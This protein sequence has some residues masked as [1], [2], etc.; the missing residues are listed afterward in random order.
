MVGAST[1]S[2]CIALLP[3]KRSRVAN[4]DKI[5][6]G[7]KSQRC[8][9]TGYSFAGRNRKSAHA[10]KEQFTRARY[11]VVGCA[12]NTDAAIRQSKGKTIACPETDLNIIT[13]NSKRTDNL[14]N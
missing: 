4:N 6:T 5:I 8:P 13:A 7:R 2:C 10:I 14:T 11:S 9:I 1:G 12:L 3:A